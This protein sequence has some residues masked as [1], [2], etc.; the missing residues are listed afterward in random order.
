[1][2]VRVTAGPDQGIGAFLVGSESALPSK[3]IDDLAAAG[4]PRNKI[5]RIGGADA[6]ATAK[7]VADRL[8]RRSTDAK[9]ADMAQGRPA[10]AAAI[11]V[12]PDA[13]GAG[14]ATALSAMLRLPI[15]YTGR[16]RLPP[17]TAEAIRT[18]ALNK[19]LVV[20]GTA[21]VSDAVVA[22]LPGATRLG[23][24]DLASVSEAVVRESAARG[25]PVNQ[26][27]VG[28]VQRPVEAAVLAATAAR[29]GG[30]FIVNE[31]ASAGEAEAV[32]ERAE[33]LPQ[34]QRVRALSAAGATSGG[35]TVRAGASAP[36]PAAAPARRGQLPATGGSGGSG[37][38]ALMALAV[39]VLSV[40][41]RLAA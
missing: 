15:L 10:F 9:A 27:F 33:V 13:P 16:D 7:L 32:L 36:A 29:L 41:R 8:D 35:S 24:D 28:D 19:T 40:R 26:T 25:L 4:V 2:E 20:G 34:V 39:A 14:S 17:P 23:G 11:L 22:S 6:A 3:V 21:A 18:F 38:L 1:M 31:G 30:L 12:N 37:A 5:V